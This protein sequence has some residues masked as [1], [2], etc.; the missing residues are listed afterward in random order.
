MES[1]GQFLK[2]EREFR[3]ITLEDLSRTTKISQ[4]SLKNIEEDQWDL[5]PKGAYLKGYL[6]SYA[7]YLGLTYEDVR[8]HAGDLAKNGLDGDDPLKGIKKLEGRNQ[9]LLIL[10]SAAALI[11]L[12]AILS[13]R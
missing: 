9:A 8:A 7:R 5:L 3:G 11:G 10:L 12:A 4:A 2:R 13:S 6:V 1:L